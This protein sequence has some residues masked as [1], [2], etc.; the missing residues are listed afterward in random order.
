[1]SSLNPH[2]PRRHSLSILLICHNEADR[3]EACLQSVAGWADEIV[4]FDS[5]SN[6]GTVGIAR[7]YSEQVHLT[8]WPGYGAQRQRALQ[9]ARGDYMLALDADERVTPA[10]REE[11]DRELSLEAPRAAAWTMRWSPLLL[12]K[13]LRF[14]GR[15]AAPQRRLFRRDRAHYAPAQVHENVSVEGPVAALDGRLEHDSFRDYRHAVDKHAQYAWLL[16][17]EK[18]AR[19]DRCGVWYAPLRGSFEFLLQYLARGLVFD[20]SRGLLLSLLLAQYAHQKYAALWSLGISGAPRL[21]S[22]DPALR[23]RGPASPHHVDT[24]AAVQADLHWVL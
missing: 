19:G 24:S 4:I 6:D 15:Y 8:D 7:R 11:I 3:I 13:P 20:G 23:Q 12:G 14:G 2:A 1:M 18:H 9:A 17:Q 22:F 5:G 16:A 10:L 21:A